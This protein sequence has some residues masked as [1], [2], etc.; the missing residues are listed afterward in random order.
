MKKSNSKPRLIQ[1]VLL[2]QEFDLYIKDK[3]GL[4]TV[5]TEH[6]SLLRPEAT[7]SEKVPMMIPCQK[8]SS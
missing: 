8:I 1:W 6:L 5:V 7:P 4:K 2:L 3:A